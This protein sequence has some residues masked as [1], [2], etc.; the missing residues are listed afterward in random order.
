MR[1]TICWVIVGLALLSAVSQ[2]DFAPLV[3]LIA[4]P[5]AIS[6]FVIAPLFVLGVLGAPVLT[7]LGVWLYLRLRHGERVPGWLARLVPARIRRVVRRRRPKPAALLRV[8]VDEDPTVAP[9]R[10]VRAGY[11][12]SDELADVLGLDS[13]EAQEVIAALEQ[14]IPYSEPPGDHERIFVIPR[15]AVGLLDTEQ[16]D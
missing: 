1:R 3:Q 2:L 13:V 9:E 6:L 11:L 15:A 4:F 8:V 5:L 7:P 14:G 10:T 16:A 12:H